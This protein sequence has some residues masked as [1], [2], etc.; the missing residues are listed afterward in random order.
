M[1]L[2]WRHGRS[3]IAKLPAYDVQVAM[4][5]QGVIQLAPKTK[6]RMGVTAPRGFGFS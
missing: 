6:N 1:D 2:G 4:N 3:L 5:V